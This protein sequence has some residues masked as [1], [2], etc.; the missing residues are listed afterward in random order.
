MVEVP[1]V[2]FVVATGKKEV[3]GAAALSP[4]TNR[5]SSELFRAWLQY[6]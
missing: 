6:M 5:R 1:G 2:K 4:Q 3:T